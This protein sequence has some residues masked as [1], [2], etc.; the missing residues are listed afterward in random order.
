MKYY[1]IHFIYFQHL[2]LLC[3]GDKRSLYPHFSLS[4]RERVLFEKSFPST[5]GRQ[6]EFALAKRKQ[7]GL[8]AG[9]EGKRGFM[10]CPY[11]FLLS[12][13]S[14]ILIPP[15]PNPPMPPYQRGRIT[16]NDKN[17]KFIMTSSLILNDNF[18]ELLM[19]IKLTS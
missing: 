16:I 12:Y 15:V 1:N 4:Q 14:P 11:F 10:P 5:Y 3:S 7:P 13:V 8:W 19:T 18:C 9:G 2:Y 6:G 17:R